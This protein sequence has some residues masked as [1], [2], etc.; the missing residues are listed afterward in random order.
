MNEFH[1]GRP[2]ERLCGRKGGWEGGRERER[3]RRDEDYPEAEFIG[4]A[5][6]LSLTTERKRTCNIERKER[7]EEESMWPWNP[8]SPRRRTF[9]PYYRRRGGRQTS[10]SS[11]RERLP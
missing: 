11:R 2:R 3:E 10:I 5:L 8:A 9:H 4:M 1:G 7:E 6:S